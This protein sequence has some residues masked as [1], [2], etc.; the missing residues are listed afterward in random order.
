[1]P[2]ARAIH[3]SIVIV[4][5]QNAAEAAVADGVRVF[6]VQHL[7]EVIALL[8]SPDQF[9]PVSA[10]GPTATRPVRRPETA[11]KWNPGNFRVGRQPTAIREDSHTRHLHPADCRTRGG[12]RQS[13]EQGTGLAHLGS[14]N[15]THATPA[16]VLILILR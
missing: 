8:K 3:L 12:Q 10:P 9:T 7:S 6:G 5:R 1:L 15:A 13:G 4:P 16:P 2:A 11:A 14:R